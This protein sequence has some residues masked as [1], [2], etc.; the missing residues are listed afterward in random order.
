MQFIITMYKKAYEGYIWLNGNF[1]FF[2]GH[3][4]NRNFSDEQLKFFIEFAVNII[5]TALQI[6]R[7][8]NC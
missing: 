2:R 6:D 5:Y 3:F 8:K 1:C 7:R 4:L